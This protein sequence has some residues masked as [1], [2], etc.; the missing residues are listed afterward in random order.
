MTPFAISLSSIPPRF[1]ALGPT[2]ES[3]LAQGAERVLLWIPGTYRRFP[4]WDGALPEVPQG[5]EICRCD[6][7]GP[8]T[9]VLPAALGRV[10]P[11]ILFCDDDRAYPEGWAQSFLQARADHPNAALCWRGMMV[12]WK[13]GGDP[14]TKAPLAEPTPGWRKWIA[15]AVSGGE[16]RLFQRAGFVDMVEGCGG[17]LIRP[18]MFD[19]RDAQIPDLARPVDDVWLS[20]MLARKGVPIWLL[21]G[22]KSPPRTEAHDAAPLDGDARHAQNIAAIRHLQDHFGVW[23]R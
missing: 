13:L 22:H 9:K 11:E 10:A 16:D 7:L 23:R 20:G 6:D 3:L 8:A 18:E 1:D 12:H 14:V 21:A 5:V 15:R 17:V 4:D 19:A 2:L